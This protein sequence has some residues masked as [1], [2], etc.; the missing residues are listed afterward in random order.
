MLASRS[1]RLTEHVD[2]VFDDDVKLLGLYGRYEDEMD[3]MKKQICHYI[4]SET[5]NS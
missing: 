1:V 3:E 4:N 2:M 5:F